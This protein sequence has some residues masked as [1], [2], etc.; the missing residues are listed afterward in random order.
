LNH[1]RIKRSPPEVPQTS[2]NRRI[3]PAGRR[4][5]SVCCEAMVGFR[6]EACERTV[7][8]YGGDVDHA[9]GPLGQ[10]LPNKGGPNDVDIAKGQRGSKEIWHGIRKARPG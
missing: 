4:E 6:N 2:G 1:G 8:Q 10:L 3:D 7:L 5:P 9:S